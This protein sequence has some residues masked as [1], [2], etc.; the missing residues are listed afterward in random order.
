MGLDSE[1]AQVGD[2]IFVLLGC[3]VPVVLRAIWNHFQYIDNVY[4]EGYMSGRAVAKLDEGKL[5]S[6]IFE[7][8]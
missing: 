8:H 1:E 6:Q 5:D 3:S 4:L 7:I 2:L